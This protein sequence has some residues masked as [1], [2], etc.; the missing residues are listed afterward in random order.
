M[1]RRLWRVIV[2]ID[3]GRVHAK[4]LVVADDRET[5]RTVGLR[6]GAGAW[7]GATGEGVVPC[8]VR[9][10]TDVTPT[11]DPREMARIAAGD[12]PRVSLIEVSRIA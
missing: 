9:S 8:L 1:A 4:V 12:A 11:R 3:D 5:A 2:K 6:A 7:H 10:T